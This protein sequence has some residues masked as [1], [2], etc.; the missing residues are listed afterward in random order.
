MTV[1]TTKDLTDF[2][3]R[4]DAAIAALPDLRGRA[5]ERE[6]TEV[7][8]ILLRVGRDSALIVMDAS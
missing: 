3:K 2:A 8:A 6:R 4:L 5:H 1:T 7:K